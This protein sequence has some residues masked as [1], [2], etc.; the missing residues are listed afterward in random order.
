M[1]FRPEP[2]LAAALAD[3]TWD[4]AVGPLMEQKCT[5]CH[6]A[7]LATGSLVLDTY[8]A[9]MFGSEDGPVI[10]PGDAEG[11]RLVEVQ[12]GGHFATLTSEELDIV[13]EWINRGAPQN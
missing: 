8:N 5:G 13:I 7:S 2:D 6:N 4:D 1:G 3:P 12:R 9:A 11:S 10:V